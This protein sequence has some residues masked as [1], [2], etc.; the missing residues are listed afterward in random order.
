MLASFDGKQEMPRIRVRA[1]DQQIEHEFGD[2]ALVTGTGYA[3][4]A[5]LIGRSDGDGLSIDPPGPLPE[6]P[7]WKQ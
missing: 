1:V 2:H 3:L 5:W 7:A 4:L 6:L